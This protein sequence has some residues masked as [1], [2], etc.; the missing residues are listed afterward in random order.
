MIFGGALA[1]LATVIDIMIGFTVKG[2]REKTE[3]RL[4]KWLMKR[5]A[6]ATGLNLAELE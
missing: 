4:C 6:G 5:E 3:N 1:T 2:L